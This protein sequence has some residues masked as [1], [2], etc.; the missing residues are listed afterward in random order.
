MN[1]L[2]PSES[3]SGCESGWT[4][5][6]EE[7][8]LSP[9]PSHSHDFVNYRGKNRDPKDEDEEEDL[10]MV[11]DASSGPQI[12]HEN[13]FYGN[14]DNGFLSHAAID[15]TLLKNSANKKMKKNRGNRIRKVEEDPSFLDDTASSPI[16]NFSQSNFKVSNN[17][18]SM[19]GI[20]DFSQGCSA[21][22]VEGSSEFHEPFGFFQSSLPGNQLHQSQW[23]GGKMGMR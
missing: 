20:L 10:S 18:A 16:F 9:Y 7:S 5:Y 3:S 6:L 17:Q 1:N 13:E 11:S 15:A 8:F 4:L 23:F 22:H 21:T 19:E 14:A 12:F 2:L